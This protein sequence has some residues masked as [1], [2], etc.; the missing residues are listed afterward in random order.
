MNNCNTQHSK[1][2]GNDLNIYAISINN[3]KDR[4]LTIVDNKR[5]RFAFP[6]EKREITVI[7]QVKNLNKDIFATSQ[8]IESQINS[9]LKLKR[10]NE[11]IGIFFQC[12]KAFA[13]DNEPLGEIKDHKVDI[14]LNLKRTYPPI[15]R[16]PAYPAITLTREAIEAHIDEKMKLVSL[17]KAGKN[18]EVEV[19][20]P[21]IITLHN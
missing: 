13:S 5:K 11:L 2:E 1:I 14:M 4:Y 3:H 6:L 8:L 21:V 12:K 16:R 18:E 10:K 20:T 19:T 7:K 15:L 17:R 9:K